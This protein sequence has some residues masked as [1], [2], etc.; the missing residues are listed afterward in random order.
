MVRYTAPLVIAGNIN[1]NAHPAKGDNSLIMRWT[2]LK[3]KVESNFALAVQGRV[4]LFQTRYRRAHRFC[5]DGEAWLVL[6]GKKR[7]AWGD[8]NFVHT[9]AA[10]PLQAKIKDKRDALGADFTELVTAVLQ[11][12]RCNENV[13]K[14][15]TRKQEMYFQSLRNLDADLEV[16]GVTTRQRLNALLFDTLSLSIDRMVKHP[17]PIVRGL[18]MLDRRFGKR[19]LRNRKTA[20]EHPF[21]R[22]M[23]EFRCAAEGIE[24]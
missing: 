13:A 6:D 9:A 20:A 21:V 5:G 17:S 24:F 10:S 11:G 14:D 4:E 7:Y 23:F 19:R 2:Q 12:T 3:L 18:A 16:R 1:S 22:G 8:A 15:L